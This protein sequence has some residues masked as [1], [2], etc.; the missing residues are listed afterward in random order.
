MYYLDHPDYGPIIKTLTRID[1]PNLW[2]SG[3]SAESLSSAAIGA[4]QHRQVLGRV[5]WVIS[6]R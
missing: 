1:G 3:E 2:F 4:L 6:P 5:I